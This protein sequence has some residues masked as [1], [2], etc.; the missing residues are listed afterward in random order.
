VNRK[1][2]IGTRR[3]P[4]QSIILLCGKCAR[5]LD[6]GTGRTENAALAVHPAHGPEGCRPSPRGPHHRDQVYGD[7]PEEGRHSRECQPSGK[8]LCDSRGQAARRSAEDDCRAGKLTEGG[9]DVQ[10]NALGVVM[11]GAGCRRRASRGWRCPLPHAWAK[12]RLDRTC[13]CPA[14]NPSAMRSAD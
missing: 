3:T 10:C 12:V 5:K 4:W 7:M 2:E 6:G 9:F 8:N 1:R 13:R 11:L 14:P